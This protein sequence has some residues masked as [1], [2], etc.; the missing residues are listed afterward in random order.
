MLKIALL[1]LT[2]VVVL[3]AGN[4]QTNSEMDPNG[5]TFNIIQ[6]GVRVGYAQLSVDQ[7]TGE[8]II[9]VINTTGSR[10]YVEVKCKDTAVGMNVNSGSLTK[11]S[12]GLVA[13][14]PVKFAL[15][16]R[17]LFACSPGAVEITF[18]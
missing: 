15:K 18:K 5:K 6:N 10:K 16:T 3:I 14:D 17:S 12:I 9:Y 1:I 13:S 7:S 4:L 8:D 11:Q 2:T